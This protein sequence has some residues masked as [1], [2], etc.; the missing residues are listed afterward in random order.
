[1]NENRAIEAEEGAM[2][3]GD[4][5]APA[6]TPPPAASPFAANA[7]DIDIVSDV[8]CPWC[9]VGR[10]RFAFALAKTGLSVRI[11]WHPFELNPQLPKEGIERRLYRVRKFGS[12]E[13]SQQLDA[14]LAAV[15]AELGLDFRYDRITRTPNTFDAH[16]LLWR[17]RAAGVQDQLSEAL[18][19]AY[20]AEG[21]DV[22]DANVL[23]D[24][25]EPLGMARGDTLA[26]LA[27]S[28]GAN[29]VRAEEAIV[30]R[31]GISGVPAYFANGRALFYGAQPPEIM[32]EA[33][34]AAA[35][36]AGA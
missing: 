21:R 4:G 14:Q 17:A 1:M 5:C 9:W 19:R 13:R 11:A 12:L 29:E 32:A 24:V 25:A 2:C 6:E 15:G 23:A 36:L 31:A 30:Q 27:G 33:L 28:G 34:T 7:L 18:F 3:G 20:F 35:S 10:K 16:R 22:G 8:I 26:F